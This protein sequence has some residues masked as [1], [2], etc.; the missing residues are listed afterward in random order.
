MTD[1]TDESRAVRTPASDP[2][3]LKVRATYQQSPNANDD[4]PAENSCDDG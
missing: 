4:E 2:A 1:I 3:P